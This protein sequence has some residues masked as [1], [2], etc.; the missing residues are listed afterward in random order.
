MPP[1]KFLKVRTKH[2]GLGQSFTAFHRP[3]R[4]QVIHS[5]VLAS[6]LVG[7]ILGVLVSVIVLTIFI[8]ISTGSEA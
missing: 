5:L 2:S 8:R 4:V 6:R 1:A 7:V 3:T